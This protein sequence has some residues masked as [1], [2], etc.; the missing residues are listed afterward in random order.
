ML[1]AFALFDFTK[2][3]IDKCSTTFTYLVSSGKDSLLI[4]YVLPD[5]VNGGNKIIEGATMLH[6]GKLTSSF[7]YLEQ[8]AKH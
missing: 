6:E 4:K 7:S 2:L 5:L 3:S 1:T 8:Y